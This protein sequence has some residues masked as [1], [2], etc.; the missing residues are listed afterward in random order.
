ME[1]K[2][3]EKLRMCLLYVLKNNFFVYEN[4]K[5]KKQPKNMLDN[6]KIENNFL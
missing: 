6:Q 2:R 3:K 5:K 1:K 4:K